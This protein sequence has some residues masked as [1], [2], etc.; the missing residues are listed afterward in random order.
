MQR[1]HATRDS[2]LSDLNRAIAALADQLHTPQDLADL[3]QLRTLAARL[4]APTGLADYDPARFHHLLALA[5]PAMEAALLTHLANDLS[6]CATQ[7]REGVAGQDWAVLRDGSHVLISLA[8]SVGAHSLQAMAEQLNRH[9]HD[10][11]PTA[12]DALLPRLAA[13]LEAL[14]QIVRAT[15]P[16]ASPAQEGTP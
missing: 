3:A 16:G 12:V 11:S 8:G 14:L 4:A 10:Q 5:G 13:E 6:T 1:L 7:L 9:A 15:K 2:A